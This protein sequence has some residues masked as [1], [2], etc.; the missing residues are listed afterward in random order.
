MMPFGAS[1]SIP[2][3]TGR[4]FASASLHTSRREAMERQVEHPDLRPEAIRAFTTSVLTDLRAL[5]QM[6]RDGWIEEGVRR[7]GAEQE[8][9]LVGADWRPAPLAMQVLD[10]LGGPPFTT[11]LALFNLEASLEPIPLRDH[12]FQELHDALNRAVSQVSEA[13]ALDGAKVVLAGH[14]P[15]LVKSDLTLDQIT[16]IARYYA[17]NEALTRL[18]GGEYHLQ[19]EGADELILEHDS[20]ML[21]AC[22]ASCQVHLQ[23]G[24]EEFPRLY[25]TAQLM[26]APVLAASVNSPLLFGRRLWAETR[27][28]LFQQSLDTRAGTP[29]Q[30]DLSTRVR[31]GNRWVA[32]SVVELLEEDLSQFKVLMAG[33]VEEDPFQRLREGLVPSLDALQLY[34]STI[35]RW[36][37]PC[38]GISD[39]RPHLRIECRVLPA[40]PSAVDE[41]ANAAFWIGLVLGASEEFGNPAERMDFRDAKSNF[42]AAARSG[43]ATGVRW[44]D[45]GI[46]DVRSLILT[47][48][49]PVARTG[50]VTAGVHAT[51]VDRYLSVIER[52]VAS[53]Q[54]GSEW[55]H[56]SLV[57]MSGKGTRSGRLAALTAATF[58]RQQED[59]PVDRWEPA[60]LSEAGGAI[61]NYLRVE[62]YMH[63]DLMTVNEDESVDLVAFV[64]D[65]E[66]IQHIP[67]ED[68]EHRLVG[69][70]SYRSILRY[71]GGRNELESAGATSV[72]EI[73]GGEP[74][75]VAP[76]TSTLEAIRLMRDR[77]VA[78]LPVLEEGKLVGIVT[79]RDF[80]P[81][82]YELLEEHFRT[83]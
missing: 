47:T 8:M 4:L 66:R 74:V 41:V 3:R 67:V 2:H 58:H 65:R 17:L 9:F 5:E 52:R 46:V 44:L 23:V 80:M 29:H 62:Q 51:N 32:E 10:R 12:C 30:R 77:G 71:V 50:L 22:N 69:V 36:N 70:V 83:E 72:R 34:S 19:I 57:A 24:V 68:S 7:I 13:A 39:G 14:L 48:L 54:T 37:R 61:Q 60:E 26:V 35:Y 49:L 64:M 31:F 79:D 43:L 78:C 73:M 33:P 75:T 15:T 18:R 59:T 53:G 27:I 28:A 40:G 1:R 63:T 56:R 38:Y 55:A 81:I 11:E 6:L 82:A 42:I 25:N 20:L 45:G 21:E 16:P 76:K